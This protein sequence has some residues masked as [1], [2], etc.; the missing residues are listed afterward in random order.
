MN[1][2]TK[3]RSRLSV[4]FL[5][6]VL[7]F[8]A[9]SSQAGLGLTKAIV[10]NPTQ[11]PSGQQFTNRLSYSAASTTTD[12][13]GVTLVDVLPPELSYISS[14]GTAHTSNITYN[15]ATRTVRVLFIEPLPAGSTG[16]IDLNVKFNAG[17]T[18]DGTVATNTATLSAT[19]ETPAIAPPVVIRAT[20]AD[21]VIA[22]KSL[23]NPSVPLNQN[24]TYTVAA[25]TSSDVGALKFTNLTMTDLLPVGSV[26]V[27]AS[28]GGVYDSEAGTVTW[29]VP[30]IVPG[31][32]SSQSRT[33]TLLYP[34][35]V[36]AVGN[37]VTNGVQVTGT[38]LGGEATNHVAWN[39]SPIV[40]PTATSTFT[41]SVDGNYVYDG[42]A[43]AK[44][45]TLAPKN[46]GNTPLSNV[47]VTDAVPA[48]VWVYEIYTGVYSG[49]PS[50][51][52]TGIT[53]EYRTNLRDWTTVAGSEYALAKAPVPKVASAPPFHRCQC[54]AVVS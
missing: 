35:P 8:A 52:G 45:Y 21:T 14:Q 3:M 25:T 38:P 42:K 12:F 34:S 47:V 6:L 32:A 41:K 15:A 4:A 44:T 7:A 50:G 2:K 31:T 36:F 46:T 49:S 23:I 37:K 27:S 54:P 17:V 1:D 30:D 5:S 33:I 13:H 20:A 22:T 40:T 53:V 24:I 16:Q 29:S 26:F 9:V 11:V 48:A 19:G 18:P 10:G 43:I 51:L 28:G 39:I